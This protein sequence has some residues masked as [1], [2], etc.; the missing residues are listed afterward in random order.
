MKNLTIINHPLAQHKLSIIRDKDTPTILFRALIKEVGTLLA[1]SVTADLPVEDIQVTTPLTTMTGKRIA[2]KK[3]VLA[4]VLRAGAGMMDGFL[5]VCPGAKIGHIGIYRDHNTLE[6]KQYLFRMPNEVDQREVVIIDPMLATGNS[7]VAAIEAVKKLNP[8]R[9]KLATLIS[10]PE[11]VKHV[12]EQCPDV[13]IFTVSVDQ[14]LNDSAYI[15]P[16][17]GDAGDRIFGTV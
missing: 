8:K 4:P 9:I 2:G 12:N 1:Y 10:A 17:L 14:K 7:A 15:V 5:E 3:L 6:A 13:S 16:G 11:G